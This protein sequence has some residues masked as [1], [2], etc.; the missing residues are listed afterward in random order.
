MEGRGKEIRNDS[1]IRG[2]LYVRVTFVARSDEAAA[3]PTLVTRFMTFIRCATAR[4]QAASVLREL[5]ESRSP[6]VRIL[7]FQ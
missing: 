7:R 5:R 1:A 6:R 2:S 3:R 4:E